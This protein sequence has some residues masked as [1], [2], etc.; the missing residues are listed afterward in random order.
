MPSGT[1]IQIL[2]ALKERGGESH[3]SGIAKKIRLSSDYAKI[4]CRSL[5]R[6]DYL[7]LLGTGKVRLTSKG[8]KAVGGREEEKETEEDGS[9]EAKKKGPESREEKYQRWILL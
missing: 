8:W 1:E 2:R 3:L 5:G 7:D 4:V 6:A 9:S